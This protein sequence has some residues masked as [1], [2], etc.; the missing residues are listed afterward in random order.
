[1]MRTMSPMIGCAFQR[2]LS[3][4]A[5]MVSKTSGQADWYL[6]E[7][8]FVVACAILFNS[9]ESSLERTKESGI[10]FEMKE[11]RHWDAEVRML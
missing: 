6:T 2:S 11:M 5:T 9:G 7:R 10:Q 1:M 8:R 4:K 3:N